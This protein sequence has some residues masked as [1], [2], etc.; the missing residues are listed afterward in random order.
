MRYGLHFWLKLALF[1]AV[2]LTPFCE[3]QVDPPLIA[4]NSAA[5]FERIDE[6]DQALQ[7]LVAMPGGPPGVIVLIQRGRKRSV[8]RAGVAK[9]G[10]RRPLLRRDHMRIASV[11]KAFSG[12]AALALVAEGMLGL[13]DTIGQRL[14]DLPPAWYPVTLRQ[15][16]N[17]TSGVPDFIESDAFKEAVQESPTRAPPP[18]G[19]LAFVA[20][21]K[22]AFDPGSAY[23]Y[24]NSDN[25]VVGLM[26]E[27][28]TGLHYARV[29][30]KKVLRPLRIRHTNLPP[31]VKLRK[32]YIRGYETD[33]SGELHD[34]S[35]VV[36]FGGWAWASGGLVST[37][38][39]LGRFVRGYVGGRLFG[40]SQRRE[41]FRFVE[42]G[43]SGPPGPGS[44][45]AGLALFRYETRCGTVFGHT[46]NILGYTHLIAATHDGDTSIV[47]SINTQI[48]ESILPRLRDAQEL[49]VCAALRDNG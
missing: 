17:H 26:I 11:S 1:A 30:R 31:G 36:A 10:R 49:A 13:E 37:P 7:E 12:A 34:V 8:H 18:R 27:A 25:I 6:L 35:E 40:A 42:G 32:P 39:N 44:N 47:F 23:K 41:Q 38:G 21:E 46:G 2:G 20:D 4:M 45:A 15:L 16:L 28:V 19:L 24:S 48:G 3:I 33:P 22:L 14:P 43:A 5:A 9:I 29:L